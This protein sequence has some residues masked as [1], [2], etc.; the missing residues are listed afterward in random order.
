MIASFCAICCFRNV[1]SADMVCKWC[2]SSLVCSLCRVSLV[3]VFAPKARKGSRY[4]EYAVS[5]AVMSS[6]WYMLASCP[7]SCLLPIRK[8]QSLGLMRVLSAMVAKRLRK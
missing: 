5:S 7:V 6:S 3:G 2:S 1:F 8:S 4:F